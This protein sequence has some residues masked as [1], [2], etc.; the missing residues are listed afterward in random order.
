LV[1]GASCD[2]REDEQPHYNDYFTLL[3]AAPSMIH[4][5]PIPSGDVHPVIQM[6]DADRRPSA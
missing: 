4:P 6:R 1:T 5:P 3:H 2:Q